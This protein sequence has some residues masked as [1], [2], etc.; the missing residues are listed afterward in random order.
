MRITNESEKCIQHWYPIIPR[1]SLWAQLAKSHWLKETDKNSNIFYLRAN[2]RR[3]QNG[4]KALT[5]NLGE[6]TFNEDEIQGILIQY[7]INKFRF[8]RQTENHI[9]FSAQTKKLNESVINHLEAL[10]I[11]EDVVEAIKGLKSNAA[12]DP[13]GILVIFYHKYWDIVGTYL[14][15]TI[16]NF[17]NNDEN[18]K[19]FNNMYIYHIPKTKYH[20]KTP[21]IIGL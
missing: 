2:S 3:N 4:I 16:L 13:N 18:S 15:K 1:G 12:P 14:T 9:C 20:F 21:L 6:L 8:E 7:Y 17:L 11:E 5:T 19:R 10:F